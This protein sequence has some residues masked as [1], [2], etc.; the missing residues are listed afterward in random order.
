MDVGSDMIGMFKTNAKV[1][2]NNYTNNMTK[3]WIGG[4]YLML[5]RKTRV[6]GD[7]PLIAVGYS[8][9]T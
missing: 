3:Y 2:C 6:P 5:K 9:N 1:F 7:R 4:F 8:Y